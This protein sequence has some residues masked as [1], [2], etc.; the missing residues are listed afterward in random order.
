MDRIQAME[1]FLQVAHLGSFT[2][3]AQKLEMSTAK[4]SRYISYLEDWLGIRLFNRT[5][6][7]V[8][9]TTDGEQALRQCQQ[10]LQLVDGV[11][12]VKDSPQE[13][14]GSIRITTSISFAITELSQILVKFQ[15][16]HPQVKIH[17]Q[18]ADS[19]LDLISDRI[20]LAIRFSNKI[21]ESLIARKI[22]VCHSTFVATPEYLQKHGVPHTPQELETHNFISH[23]LFENVALT[24]TKDLEKVDVITKSSFTSNDTATVMSAVLAHSGIAMLPNYLINEQVE[25]GKLQ[26]VLA[27]WQVITLDIYAV[28][29]SRQHMPARVRALIDFLIVEG[30]DKAW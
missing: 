9:L 6:R 29:T 10:I 2:E 20:D 25:A 5:T 26:V 16:L 28:Y 21:D 7:N 4:V 17:L 30:K 1:V 15:Q 24:L 27:D 13:L 14:S 11:Q 22:G 18:V 8:T 23:V 19:S 3:A 12:T